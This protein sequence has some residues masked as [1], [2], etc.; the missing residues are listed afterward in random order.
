MAPFLVLILLIVLLI[1]FVLVRSSEQP[2]RF[3][4][5]RLSCRAGFHRWSCSVS[6]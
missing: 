5:R 3:A 2:P 4:G 6:V 1:I